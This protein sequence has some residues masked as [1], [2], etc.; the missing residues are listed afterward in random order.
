M[1]YG[2]GEDSPKG[3]MTI[4]SISKSW[5]FLGGSCGSESATGSY[6]SVTTGSSEA[7]SVVEKAS[8]NLGRV[9]NYARRRS[10]AR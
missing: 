9:Q 4:C 3:A 8:V 7:A 1:R 6:E 10:E 5:G 2:C